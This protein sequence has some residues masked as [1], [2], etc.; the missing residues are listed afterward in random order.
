MDSRRTFNE[1]HNSSREQLDHEQQK[2]ELFLKIQDCPVSL[3][4]QIQILVKP[5]KFRSQTDITALMAL[6]QEIKFFTERNYQP[7][8]LFKLASLAQ[9][10]F[11]EANTVVFN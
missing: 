3:Q 1:S 9:Y 4:S 8:V 11:M 7:D 10:S 5:L 6:M 2:Q